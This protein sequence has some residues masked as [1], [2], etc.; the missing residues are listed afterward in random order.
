M[1]SP[2]NKQM[3]VRR[4]AKQPPGREYEAVS[5]KRSAPSFRMDPD[6]TC[7]GLFHGR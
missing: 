1:W 4:I 2:R 3:R 5:E 6:P 7:A